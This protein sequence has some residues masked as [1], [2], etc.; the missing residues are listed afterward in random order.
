MNISSS[1]HSAVVTMNLRLDT[2]VIPVR[3]LAPAFL[4]VD[5]CHDLA[6]TAGE[7][8]VTIDGHLTLYSVE[9]PEGI[10]SSR[11]RQPATF[12]PVEQLAV[13]EAQ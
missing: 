4:I 5:G 6:S 7:I 3:Q 10:S 13:I 11:T 12:K 1:G 8:A 2:K 9:L